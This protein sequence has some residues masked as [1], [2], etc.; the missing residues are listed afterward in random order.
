LAID[1]P[2]E[3][4]GLIN[5]FVGL[6]YDDRVKFYPQPA[7]Q[8]K[9]GILKILVFGVQNKA[10]V[11]YQAPFKADKISLEEIKVIFIEIF[12]DGMRKEIDK[13]YPS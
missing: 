7:I 1:N 12:R 4:F 11:V 13:F 6:R 5:S 3:Y 8:I 2:T 10:K 9:D